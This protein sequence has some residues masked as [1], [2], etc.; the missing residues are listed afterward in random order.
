MRRSSGASA[1]VSRWAMPLDGSSSSTTVGRW[2]TTQARSTTRREPVDSSRANLVRNDPRPISSI[3]SSTRRRALLLGVERRREVQGGAE[4]VAHLDR[5]ARATTAMRSS[6]VRAGQSRASWNDRPSPWR[7]PAVG[8]QVGDVAAGQ[9]DPPVVGGGEAR[10]QVEQGR[11]AGAVGPDD[12]DDLPGRHRQAS[13]RHGP[14]AAEAAGQA[15]RGQ[16]RDAGPT[17]GRDPAVA[18][19][20]AGDDRRRHPRHDLLRLAGVAWSRGCVGGLPHRGA[21]P[22]E[23]HRAEHV[24]SFEQLERWGRG[25]GSG[26][27]P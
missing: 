26:P 18:V 12:P 15:C 13:R 27:S 9:L 19:G 2:A 8:A 17:V 24:G 5:S 11:L 7:G 16:R 6:T 3:S 21:G 1:S 20:P 22:F 4:G 10:D 25:S 14:D 23:E